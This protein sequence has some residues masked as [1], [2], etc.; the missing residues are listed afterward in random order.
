LA[1]YLD[2]TS[3]QLTSRWPVFYCSTTQIDRDRPTLEEDQWIPG[4][5][6]PL[7]PLQTPACCQREIIEAFLQ[8]QEKM[9]LDLADNHS[10]EGGHDSFS[11]TSHTKHSVSTTRDSNKLLDFSAKT[12]KTWSVASHI[13][14]VELHYTH[15]QDEIAT[16]NKPRKPAW[17]LP[18]CCLQCV[19]KILVAF[20]PT[21]SLYNHLVKQTCSSFL[22]TP[23]TGS[24][25]FTLVVVLVNAYFSLPMLL[26][27]L[28]SYTALI[29]FHVF[30]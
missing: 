30:C 5:Q 28:F 7:A 2:T 6:N 27:F 14:P 4:Y 9:L 23:P 20:L 10:K 11:R 29:L 17:F 8:Q 3:P 12:T 1:A 19:I 21:H 16:S 26:T 22:Y 24:R 13:T 18:M 15:L 25:F